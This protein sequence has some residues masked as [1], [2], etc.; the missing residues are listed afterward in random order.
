MAD[1]KLVRDV[2]DLVHAVPGIS[3]SLSYSEQGKESSGTL[4]LV[5]QEA[6]FPVIAHGQ[7]GERD[8]AHLHLAEGGQFG[9]ARVEMAVAGQ[10]VVQKI[11]GE[12]DHVQQ[13]VLHGLDP[14]A[15]SP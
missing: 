9:A 15:N 13:M 7:I 10:Q 4:D 14:V 3:S 12:T 1:K 6:G 5:A 11:D 2:D 8:L